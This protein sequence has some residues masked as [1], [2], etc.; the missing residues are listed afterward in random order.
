[1]SGAMD[2][3]TACTTALKQLLHT[4]WLCIVA[5]ILSLPSKFLSAATYA[6]FT[7]LAVHQRS[8]RRWYLEDRADLFMKGCVVFTGKPREHHI[9]PDVCRSRASVAVRPFARVTQPLHQHCSACHLQV[10]SA[11]ALSSQ[12]SV[13]IASY[14]G[15]GSI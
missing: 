2:C 11:S 6:A 5:F 9:S 4:L 12:C 14:G 7:P 10:S 3:T 8:V 1:M 15:L 13:G